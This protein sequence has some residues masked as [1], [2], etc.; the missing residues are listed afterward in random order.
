VLAERAA[1]VRTST[2]HGRCWWWPLPITAHRHDSGGDLSR[3]HGAKGWRLSEWAALLPRVQ[4][5]PQPRQVSS[6]QHPLPVYTNA[7]AWVLHAHTVCGLSQAE[8]AE[9]QPGQPKQAGIQRAM[10]TF[11]LAMLYSN[12]LCLCVGYTSCHGKVYTILAPTP[13]VGSNHS[14]VGMCDRGP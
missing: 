4:Q 14:V 9:A 10:S 1:A 2:R 12:L 8:E 5:V 11:D 6:A 3:T 13:M 7:A